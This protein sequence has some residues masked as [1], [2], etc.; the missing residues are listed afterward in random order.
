MWAATKMGNTKLNTVSVWTV[1][2]VSVDV[3]SGTVVARC[4]K[5]LRLS[6][7]E[8]VISEAV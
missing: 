8:P 2:I 4:E 7:N 3:Q 1:Y 6:K 5:R